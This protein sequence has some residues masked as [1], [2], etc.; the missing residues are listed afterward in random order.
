[1][2]LKPE[3]ICRHSASTW[4]DSSV[5]TEKWASFTR[6]ARLRRMWV[7]ILSRSWYHLGRSPLHF[8]HSEHL[9]AQLLSQSIAVLQRESNDGISNYDH[10]LWSLLLPE[11]WKHRHKPCNLLARL[12]P[13]TTP[14]LFYTHTHTHTWNIRANCELWIKSCASIYLVKPHASLPTSPW[15]SLLPACMHTHTSQTSQKQNMGQHK[16]WF[17]T[18]NWIELNGTSTR[19]ILPHA[20]MFLT[21]DS[22]EQ[23]HMSSISGCNWAS[24]LENIATV[25]SY[26]PTQKIELHSHVLRAW[27]DHFVHASVSM[28]LDIFSLGRPYCQHSTNER[29]KRKLG[30]HCNLCRFRVQSSSF[31]FVAFE[32]TQEHFLLTREQKLFSVLDKHLCTTWL[33]LSMDFELPFETFMW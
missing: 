28:N 11:T 18:C 13:D 4:D 14:I 8:N 19:T 1:L 2:L 32:E 6:I 7:R 10:C 22:C 24:M 31:N 5:L 20:S 12:P 23:P 27:L 29:G 17:T 26:V 33:C 15:N 3:T 21:L 9:S 25:A 16:S 30:L